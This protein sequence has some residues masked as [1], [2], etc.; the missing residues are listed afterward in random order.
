MKFLSLSLLLVSFGSSVLAMD[1]N[2]GQNGQPPVDP[3][4]QIQQPA[5]QNLQQ[6]DPQNLQQP[7]PQ[8]APGGKNKVKP[9]EDTQASYAS[10]AAALFTNASKA[11][12]GL[13]L[14][15]VTVG[16]GL[17]AYKYSP[18]VKTAVD[19]VLEAT[20]EQAE[21]LKT[22]KKK[23][24]LVAGGAA[25]VALLGGAAY[26]YDVA[27]KVVSAFSSDAKTATPKAT[28]TP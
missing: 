5:P 15:V 28:N 3:Q 16:A 4:D 21:S 14:T 7:D 6:P 1:P 26:K 13:G 20:K 11:Q 27:G 18:T 25:G 17:T 19:N 23:A 10:Q 24:A 9:G 8:P 2:A 22:D 12:L